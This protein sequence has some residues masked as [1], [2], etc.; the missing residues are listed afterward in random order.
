MAF[1]TPQFN[2]ADLTLAERVQNSLLPKPFACENIELDVRCHPA[3]SLGGDYATAHWVDEHR[4]YLA[5]CDVCGHGIAAAILANRVNSEVRRLM[6][7]APE[8]WVLIEQLNRFIH[9]NYVHTNMFLTFACLLLDFRSQ[10]LQHAGAE[11]PPLLIV[12]TNEGRTEWIPSRNKLMGYYANCLHEVPQTE[13]ALKSD[14]VLVL[15]T[16]GLTDTKDERKEL[17][18]EERLRQ[19]VVA[20][21]TKPVAS[22]AD[23]VLNEA[24]TWRSG[25]PQE[26]D[27]LLLVAKVAPSISGSS[28][29]R[30]GATLNLDDVP[31]LLG[32]AQRYLDDCLEFARGGS[33]RLKICDGAGSCRM[34]RLALS[35][36]DLSDERLLAQL[37]RLEADDWR[38]P[39]ISHIPLLAKLGEGATGAVYY[40]IHPRLGREVALKILAPWVVEKHPDL[41]HRF[42]REA[43]MAGRVYAPNLVTVFDVNTEFGLYFMEMEFVSGISAA[44][45]CEVLKEEGETGVDESIALDICIG[46]ARGLVTAHSHAIIHRDIKPENILIPR[47]GKKH[48]LGFSQAKLADL[49]IALSQEYETPHSE[50]HIVIGTPGYMAP[51]QIGLS[52]EADKPADVYG[53]GATLF[54]LLSGQLPFDA[55]SSIAMLTQTVLESPRSIHDLRPDITRATAG[56]IDRCLLKDPEARFTDGAALLEALLE[57]RAALSSRAMVKA[58][59]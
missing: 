11:H 15:F 45:Y 18:G 30:L 4:H 17:F 3:A 55:N 12:S 29:G 37:P 7:H 26:D 34:I 48:A 2:T 25:Q 22:I 33:R 43:Q 54:D 58:G 40:G 23:A 6:E 28:A 35:V 16:D 38:V 8:P 20:A 9:Q 56:L 51:E 21:R 57:C 10:T 59:V 19:V 1:L 42:I 24:N 52:G 50:A 41:I 46:A 36:Q 32:G 5:M 39:V 44:E 53:M 49:G 47:I 14:D 27:L 31:V 13:L